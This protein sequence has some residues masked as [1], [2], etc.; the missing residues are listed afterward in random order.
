MLGE[1]DRKCHHCGR[2]L[3]RDPLHVYLLDEFLEA[4]P[5]FS[6]GFL[7]VFLVLW[8]IIALSMVAGGASA[9]L[10]T[11]SLPI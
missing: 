3:G 1:H 2:Y 6:L 10:G 7:F 9:G 5:I 11:I 8:T 4:L